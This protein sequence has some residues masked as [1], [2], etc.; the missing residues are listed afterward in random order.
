MVNRVSTVYSI[1]K[2]CISISSEGLGGLTK[3]IA[4]D[5]WETLFIE[6]AYDEKTV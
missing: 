3:G 2:G 4:G 1:G 5:P 6:G